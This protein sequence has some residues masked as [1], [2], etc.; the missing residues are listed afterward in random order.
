MLLEK[1]IKL[2][3][4]LK[5]FFGVKL[6]D[7]IKLFIYFWIVLKV[8]VIKLNLLFLGM[9]LLIVLKIVLFVKVFL[10]FLL[11]VFCIFCRKFGLKGI[12]LLREIKVVICIR[13]GLLY[14]LVR[15]V[16]NFFGWRMGR[17]LSLL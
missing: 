5:I 12:K 8:L 1:L 2:L 9:V 16:I 15:F 13:D 3:I 10:F 4:L 6:I 7:L 11:R 14:F 17:L